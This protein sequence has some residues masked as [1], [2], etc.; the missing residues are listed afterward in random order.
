MGGVAPLIIWLLALLVDSAKPYT[1]VL[2]IVFKFIP[3]FCFGYGMIN[4][5]SIEAFF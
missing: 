2:E 5:G 1:D 4:L 3:S